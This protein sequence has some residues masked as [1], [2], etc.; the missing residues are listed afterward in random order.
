LDNSESPAT[1][2]YQTVGFMKDAREHILTTSLM[3]FLQK[4]FKEVTM[5]EIVEH[6]GLSKGA[7][8]HYF[9]SKEQVFEE[10]MDHFLATNLIQGFDSFSKD[11]LKNF[12]QDY[13]KDAI[14]KIKSFK[15]MRSDKEDGF[16]ANHY[17]LIFD[18]MK[19]LPSYKQKLLDHNLYELKSWKKI[20]NIAKKNGEIKTSMTDE[21]VA[22][23]FIYTSD[24][25]G[26]HLILTD[27]LGQ[28]EKLK[29]ELLSLWNRIY[30]MLKG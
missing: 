20:A 6:T 5:K 23:L 14:A 11:S 21:Q 18:A 17:F 27:S 1:F 22:K 13:I 25:F 12:Y 4:N 9:S 29:T 8:Y 15:N 10:V 19:M 7:F 26:M 24:G 30:E 16:T 28:A 3:L 2:T